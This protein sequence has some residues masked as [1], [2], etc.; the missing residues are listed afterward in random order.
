M[1]NVRLVFGTKLHLP[2]YLYSEHSKV[3]TWRH[4]SLDNGRENLS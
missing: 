1:L 4:D 2:W 3:W